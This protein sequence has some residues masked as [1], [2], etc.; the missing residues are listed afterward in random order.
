[1]AGWQTDACRP[2][3]GCLGRRSVGVCPA[4]AGAER[5][6]TVAGDMRKQPEPCSGGTGGWSRCGWQGGARVAR[7]TY[8]AGQATTALT[9]QRRRQ[10]RRGHLREAEAPPP[11]QPGMSPS[12]LRAMHERSSGSYPSRRWWGVGQGTEG[13]H[14]TTTP[15]RSGV[16]AFADCGMPRWGT[17]C[18]TGQ[19]QPT[20]ER[21]GKKR[22]R[23]QRAA[24]R[25]R[26]KT[27]GALLMLWRRERRGCV[28][29]PARCPGLRCGPGRAALDPS[30]RIPQRG[31]GSSLL[32]TPSGEQR[33]ILLAVPG[34]GTGPQ[35]SQVRTLAIR[36]TRP[37]CRCR[38]AAG[39]GPT[40]SAPG[41]LPRMG[42][43]LTSPP[44]PA[45]TPTRTPA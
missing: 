24:P 9:R 36:T 33:S 18:R 13:R 34:Q 37:V 3:C 39:N 14:L 43:R 32:G 1:M 35:H 20:E 16:R 23:Q 21:R 15:R 31:R 45:P 22:R 6:A 10:M 11:T 8:R 19:L 29:V 25:T 5:A 38:L 27:A 40:P 44:L 30:G 42:L 2:Q 41:M 26:G 28:S 12:A 4:R 17:D 7:S